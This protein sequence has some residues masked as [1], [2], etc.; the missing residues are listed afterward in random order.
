MGTPSITELLKSAKQLQNQVSQMQK[1]M[2]QQSFEASTDHLTITMNGDRQLQS[3][4]FHESARELSLESLAE[5][6][7]ATQTRLTSD[8]KKQTQSKIADLSQKVANTSQE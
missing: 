2:E 4:R 7:I 6:I 5:E 3:L 8:V 1:E